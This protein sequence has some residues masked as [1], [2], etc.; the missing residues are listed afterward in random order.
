MTISVNITDPSFAKP[1][2]IAFDNNNNYYVTNFYSNQISKVSNYNSSL[3][4][5]ST[6]W[7]TLLPYDISSNITAD[8]YG[9]GGITYNS[10]NDRLYA[11]VFFN[12]YTNGLVYRIN[13]STG[14]VD[15][16]TN[17]A[18]VYNPI[19]IAANDSYVFVGTNNTT[20][21]YCILRYDLSLNPAGLNGTPVFANPDKTLTDGLTFDSSG[22]LYSL[23]S[24]NGSV[25]EPYYFNRISNVNTTDVSNN[26]PIVDYSYN[27]NLA[28]NGGNDFGFTIYEPDISSINLFIS[29]VYN[30]N[31]M[32]YDVTNSSNINLITANYLA[33]S[34]YNPYGIA[35]GGD[36]YMYFVNQPTQPL[37]GVTLGGTIY[38]QSY[39]NDTVI[40]VSINVTDAS[41][42]VPW[43][44]AFD[45]NTNYYVTNFNSNQ[46]STINNYNSVTPSVSTN[47]LTV[48]S[49]LD[50]TGLSGIVYNNYYLYCCIFNNNSIY[51][52]S[53]L[54]KIIDA[55][56]QNLSYNPV[57][58][59][60]NDSYVFVGTNNTT[61][62]YCILRYDLSLNPAGLNGT[63]VFANPDK[64][65]TDGL[66]FDSSGNLYSLYSINGSVSEPYYFNRISN[67]NT[68]DVSNNP[69]IVD[70]SYNTNLA[71]NG[72]N[73]F[74]FQILQTDT[75]INLF[76]SDV[77]NNN[78]RQYD[79]TNSSNINLITDT[80]LAD[81]YY[82]P[83]GIAFNNSYMYFVDQPIQTNGYIPGGA[84]YKA[85][86]QSCF[87]HDTKILCLN[88]LLQEEYIPIQNLRSGDIVKTYLHGYRRI[89]VIGKISFM[90][91]PNLFNSMY[92]M[93]KTEQNGLLEDLLITGGHS[94]MVDSISEEEHKRYGELGLSNFFEENKIDDKKAL[95]ACVSD[96][97]VKLTD[98]N[99]YTCYQIIPE[100]DGNDDRRFCVWA[101]GILTE[102]SSKKYFKTQD[103]RVI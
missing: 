64:T 84:V 29:D 73:D 62:D 7:L 79:V 101:N 75:S 25:S 68:T 19:C 63:P 99:I 18:T 46:I 92:K 95:L 20:K 61:K 32:Q 11:T 57:C 74:G 41:F 93:E 45:D 34:S 71:Y 97:F 55:S 48:K 47:W 36:G 49:T 88:K 14:I 37:I 77:A 56:A 35:F 28:Y 80:Y 58:I 23:Y 81:F 78:I 53:T 89:N 82:N 100:N 5:V 51:K 26:P 102:T 42:S 13:P 67:V 85:V 10:A 76:M 22:N 33:D 6:N 3:I 40:D 54:T 65:L 43:G 1:W 87:N 83:Y 38:K 50:G 72:G 39:P 31:I 70:Y 90:N 8:C 44:I 98:S 86:T 27:T 16:F 15:A 66:T 52:I 24:I 2:G 94:I 9:A 17:P 103:Y 4:N 12:N 91:T 59:V 30:N 96:E 21:D 60:A 69:P